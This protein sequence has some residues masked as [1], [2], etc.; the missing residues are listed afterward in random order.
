MR[1]QGLLFDSFDDDAAQDN[2]IIMAWQNNGT[3]L[4]HHDT[5]GL[6]TRFGGCRAKY[7]NRKKP[8]GVLV[9]YEEE[10]QT[11]KVKLNMGGKSGW[12]PCVAKDNI[13][14]PKNPYLGFTAA[15]RKD[16]VGDKH[17]V[18]SFRMWDLKKQYDDEAA[19]EAA[20]Q[21]KL[22]REAKRGE[23]HPLIEKTIKGSDDLHTQLLSNLKDQITRDR[24]FKIS[25][26][27]TMH[28]L[29]NEAPE[30][31]SPTKTDPPHSL[32]RPPR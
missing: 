30:Q 27:G 24:Q 12:E 22:E 8:V 28:T 23:A 20:E 11:F 3:K 14:L 32:T 16:A 17:E 19:A 10:K 1:S 26:F 6:G 15:N 2:P 13:E 25:E 29:L 21:K 18:R 9:S 31:H 5:D 4:F 7:R